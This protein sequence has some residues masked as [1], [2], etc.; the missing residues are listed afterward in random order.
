MNSWDWLVV[1]C[2]RSEILKQKYSSSFLKKFVTQLNFPIVQFIQYVKNFLHSKTNSEA[3]TEASLNWPLFTYW[4]KFLTHFYDASHC[5]SWVQHKQEYSCIH[6][7][8]LRW[9]VMLHCH[10]T[11][12]CSRELH[13]EQ[14][15]SQNSHWAV[16][17][18]TYRSC[19]CQYEDF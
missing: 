9:K 1:V 3:F 10:F 13:L 2:F 8:F 14:C 5:T 16:G 15:K 6:N 18:V 17:M 4:C 12:S 19:S 7:F 11:A